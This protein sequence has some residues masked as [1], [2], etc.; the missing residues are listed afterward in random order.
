[1]RMRKH[2]GQTSKYPQAPKFPRDGPAF[3]EILLMGHMI[4]CKG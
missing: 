2:K 1:M 3:S 4:L